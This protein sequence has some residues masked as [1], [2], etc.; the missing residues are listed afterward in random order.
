MN[1]FVLDA[2]PA[3]AAVA[4]CDRHVVKM[5]VETA[6]MLSTAHHVI[7]GGYLPRHNGGI[8][9]PTH[10]A[11]PCSVWARQSVGNYNWLLEL[12]VELCKEYTHRYG[13]VHKTQSIMSR[14][15]TPPR[16]IEPYGITPWAQAVGEQYKVPNNAILAYRRYYR[17]A[18]AHILTYKNRRAPLWLRDPEGDLL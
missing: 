9:L 11:H 8:Y 16:N 7:D 3:R 1:I 2:D 10:R 13:K 15:S 5:I 6:Q 4:H 17:E 18:K 14:L 12:G